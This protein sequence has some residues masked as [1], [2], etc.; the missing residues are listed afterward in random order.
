M[1]FRRAVKGGESL[2][3]KFLHFQ[4]GPFRLIVAGQGVPG[5]IGFKLNRPA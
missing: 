1:A 4:K 5:P 2:H 3:K